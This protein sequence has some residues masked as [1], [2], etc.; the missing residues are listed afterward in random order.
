MVSDST[1]TSVPWNGCAASTNHCISCSCSSR[2]S[3]EGWNSWSTQRSAAAMSAHEALGDSSAN[4]ATV[5]NN[6]LFMQILPLSD[7]GP[8]PATSLAAS[9]PSKDAECVDEREAKSPPQVRADQPEPC[10]MD[11]CAA[12]QRDEQ[13]VAAGGVEAE[14]APSRRAARR[15]ELPHGHD[16]QKGGDGRE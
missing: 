14:H 12:E 6:I 13:A 4:A 9:H 11:E 1:L 3:V 7:A 2:V 15:R 5:P 8:Q 10:E 16:R